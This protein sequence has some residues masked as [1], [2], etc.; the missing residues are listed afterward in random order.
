MRA[1]ILDLTSSRSGWAAA[2]GLACLATSGA[3][4]GILVKR[5]IS[6][7]KPGVVVFDDMC[8]L[9]DYFDGLHDSTIAPPRE[10]SGKDMSTDGSKAVG[11]TARYRFET[12]FQLHHLRK[13][14]TENWG[15]LPEAVSKAPA[16]DL[17][18]RWSEK[19]GVKR[20]VTT[21]PA[22]LRADDKRWD[23]PYHVCLSDL[24][25]GEELYTTRRAVLELPPP[26]PSPF[27]KKKPA[28]PPVV[29][30]AP[31]TAPAAPAAATTTPAPSAT[32]APDASSPVATAPAPAPAVET[33]PAPA[34]QPTGTTAAEA[35]ARR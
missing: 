10:I 11:G 24:M 22:L 14:L 1:R 7:V 32:P 5:D 9:Q 30:V 31:A 2:L 25:F 33:T 18:V 19:A 3:G 4:C 27:S 8:G 15:R 13:L 16:L 21:E 35:P 20:V 28:L 23:L 26:P 34:A 17:E 29:A 12:E 6:A